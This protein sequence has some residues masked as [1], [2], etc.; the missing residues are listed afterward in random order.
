[1]DL[2]TNTIRL[3]IKELRRT[4]IQPSRWKTPSSWWHVLRENN[5]L[6]AHACAALYSSADTDR[7]KDLFNECNVFCVSPKFEMPEE[8]AQS[9]WEAP[10]SVRAYMRSMHLDSSIPTH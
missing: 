3:A 8:W 4:G 1:M 9:A 7:R 5:I 2:I 10:L 6:S